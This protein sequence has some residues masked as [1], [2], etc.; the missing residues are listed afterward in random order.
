MVQGN[1]EVIYL[2]NAVLYIFQAWGTC[3]EYYVFDKFK[4]I[5]S[6]AIEMFSDNGINTCVGLDI[7]GMLWIC[8]LSSFGNYRS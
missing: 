7:A 1:N 8:I 2:E 3:F 4:M 5:D 6:K